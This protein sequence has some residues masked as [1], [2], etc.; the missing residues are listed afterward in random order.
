MW[1]K[2]FS[3]KQILPFQYTCKFSSCSPSIDLCGG[4]ISG[5]L[6]ERRPKFDV[7][8]NAPHCCN[9]AHT[10]KV[11]EFNDEVE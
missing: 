4:F 9:D 10:H 1:S 6:L 2:D 11:D 5:S 7:L 8:Q 3:T